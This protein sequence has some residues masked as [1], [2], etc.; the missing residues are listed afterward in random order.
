MKLVSFGGCSILK[1]LVRS[2]F[3]LECIDLN[4]IKDNLVTYHI[5]W[6]Q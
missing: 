6:W 5:V 2:A 4:G 1:E 3:V